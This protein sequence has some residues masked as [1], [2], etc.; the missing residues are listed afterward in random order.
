MLGLVV[1][2]MAVPNIACPLAPW[3]YMGIT[4]MGANIEKVGVW[5]CNSLVSEWVKGFVWGVEVM[6]YDFFQE[7]NRRLL[8]GALASVGKY[9]TARGACKA[10]QPTQS[11]TYYRS[12][13]G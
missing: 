6:A 10:R 11:H 1:L 4:K 12:R 2:L 5:G 7:V 3:G 9:G 8:A 13:T